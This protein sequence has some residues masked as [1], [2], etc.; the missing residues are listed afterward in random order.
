MQLVVIALSLVAMAVGSPLA[1]EWARFKVSHGKSYESIGEEYSRFQIYQSNNQLI[2]EHNK[3]FEMG[4]ESYSMEMN[5]FG[6]MTEA[7]YLNS[8]LCVNISRARG[9]SGAAQELTA[10]QDL[11]GT[12]DWREIGFVTPVKNQGMCGSCWAFSTTGSLEGQVFSRD[13]KLVGLSEQNLVDCSR[14]YGNNGCQGGLMDNSFNYIIDNGGIDTEDSYPYEAK[15]NKCRFNK[16]TIGAVVKS[17]VDVTADNEIELQ[18]AVATIGPIS[19]AIDASGQFRFYKKGIYYNSAC[20]VGGL[21]HAVLA[22]G[23]GQEDGKDYW[24]VKNS[25][26][27]KWGDQGYIKMT[28]NKRNHCGIASYASYPV[29]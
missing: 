23:Y 19:V 22:V 10:I 8:I 2:E 20:G 4:L 11:P 9:K 13:G 29:L 18:R 7:E 24:L 16:E 28:R 3:R 6:D 5:Q 1:E 21:N 15:D 12:V 26:G 27:T 25:W 17:F 14:S